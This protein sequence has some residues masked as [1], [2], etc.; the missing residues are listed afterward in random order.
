M[1]E[2]EKICL[3]MLSGWRLLKYNSGY[4]AEPKTGK[5]YWKEDAIEKILGIGNYDV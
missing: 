4:W 2:E 1:T 5:F 3:L